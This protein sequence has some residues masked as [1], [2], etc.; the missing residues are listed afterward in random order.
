MNL[1]ALV[2]QA[3]ST[4]QQVAA[5]RALAGL[6]VGFFLFVFVFGIAIVAFFIWLLWRIFT[7]AGMS[8]ALSLLVLV[9]GVGGIIVLCILAFGTWKVVPAP[10]QYVAGLPPNYPPQAPLPPMNNP[11]QY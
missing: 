5:Q 3:D 2:L 8:G 9:P 11:S 1:L 7:K 4:E 10:V 6:G